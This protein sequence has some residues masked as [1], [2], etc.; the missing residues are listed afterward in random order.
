MTLGWGVVSTGR[1][2]DVLVGPAINTA[3]GS[4]I[5]AVFSRD[6][7]RADEYAARHDVAKAYTSYEEML[8]DP[9]VDVVYI[10]SPNSMHYEQVMAAAKAGKHVYC[11]KP[12]AMN[13]EEAR[14]AVEACRDAGVKLGVNFQTRHYAANREA[15]RLIDEGA[16]GEIRLMEIASCS[17]VNPL[18]GWRTDPGLAGMG[19]LNNITVHPLDLACYFANSEV[20]EVVALTNVGRSD[21]LETLPIVLLRFES[22]AMAYIN[23]NQAVPNPR[24]DMEVYGSEGRIS[25]RSTTRPGMDGELLVKTNDGDERSTPF[26]TKDGFKRAIQAFNEAITNNTEANPSGV[27][28]LRSVELVE[29][30]ARSARD[31]AVVSVGKTAVAG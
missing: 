8:A 9:A 3:E 31:G 21:E 24:A 28:G 20:T 22:G 26:D 13:A 27:D 14:R 7:G 19:A 5:T 23:G 12:L 25:G 18:R 11:D 10:A 6:K 1:A 17:G 2:A 30:I 4:K 15:K 29:A 16:V